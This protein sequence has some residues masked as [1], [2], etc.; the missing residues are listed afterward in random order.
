MD[1]MG[2]RQGCAKLNLVGRG[3]GGA[4]G[5]RGAVRGSSGRGQRHK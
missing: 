4:G 2:A 1:N 3:S 5:A